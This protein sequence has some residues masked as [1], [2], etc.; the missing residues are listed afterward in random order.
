[1]LYAIVENS[2]VTNVMEWDGESKWAPPEGSTL[3]QSDTAGVGDTYD[4]TTFTRPTPPTPAAP[5]P[6][7][8][9]RVA[10]ALEAANIDPTLKQELAGV[11]RALMS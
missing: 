10:A 7:Q 4:G 5:T 1:M 2:V 3:V 11:I 6:S 8:A 9:E